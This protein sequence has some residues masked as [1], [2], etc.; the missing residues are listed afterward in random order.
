MHDIWNPWHGCVKCSEGCE[1]CYMYFLDR[2]REKDGA[3][4]YRTALFDYPLKR[5]R[6]GTYKIKSGET[7]RVCMTSDFFLEEADAWRADAWDIM[8]QR[9]DV[10]FFLLT[11]RPE[12]VP[13]CLPKDW[14]DGWENIFFNVTAENQKRADERIP[15]LLSLPFKHK[16]VMCAPFI[17]EV[18]LKEYLSSGQI[19]QVICGGENYDGARPCD[20]DWVKRLQYE[21]KEENVTFCF[22]ETGT[23]F[24]KDGKKYHLPKKSLQSEM[25]LKSGM[26]FDGKPIKFH[27]TDMLGLEIP[28]GIQYKPSFGKTCVKCA[29]RPICN[30]CSSCGACNENGRIKEMTYN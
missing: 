3:E 22:I 5:N 25:A 4:I 17:G 11:K 23:V 29:S 24:I 15:I 21:C 30:G 7:L 14:G 27:L 16:G 18:S 19:E 9:P 8:R 12:R 6:D 2:M 10:K 20:F 26:N 28:E 1:N 13:K